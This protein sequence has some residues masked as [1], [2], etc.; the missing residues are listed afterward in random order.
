MTPDG[1]YE[2]QSKL[3]E[4][5]G[6]PLMDTDSA[7]FAWARTASFVRASRWTFILFVLGLNRAGNFARTGISQNQ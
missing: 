2:V 6:R 1:E 3:S 5:I 7:G 4:V